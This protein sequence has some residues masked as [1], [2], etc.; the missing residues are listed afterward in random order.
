MEIILIFAVFLLSFSPLN[1]RSGRWFSLSVGLF[2]VSEA[3][4]ITLISLE[5]SHPDFDDSAGAAFVGVLF[6]VPAI[7]FLFC[8]AIRLIIRAIKNFRKA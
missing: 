3:A 4:L 6:T 1:M 2:I 5:L 7:I 8:F